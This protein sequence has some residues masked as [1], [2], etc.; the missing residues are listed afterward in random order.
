VGYVYE[1]KVEGEETV[2]PRP[3]EGGDP[4]PPF[5]APHDLELPPELTTPNTL[6]YSWTIYF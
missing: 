3:E 2:E 5:V 6:R 4:G 1:D